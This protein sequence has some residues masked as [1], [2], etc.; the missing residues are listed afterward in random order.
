MFEEH[1]PDT[2]EVVETKEAHEVTTDGI[3]RPP[4]WRHD[5]RDS[6]VS[7]AQPEFEA[8]F[9]AV[10]YKIEGLI[11]KDS[12]GYGYG[13]TSLG[14][15]L[16][17]VLK[18]M[19]DNGLTIRQY[20]GK[21]HGLSGSGKQVFLPVNTKVTHAA[22]GQHEIFVTEV[23]LEPFSFKD[24]ETKKTVYTDILTPQSLGAAQTYARRYGLLAYFGIA[25]VD[26]D[27]MASFLEAAQEEDWK[28]CIE[29]M[30]NGMKQNKTL[31]ELKEWA[32]KNK[33]QI[34][35]IE[36]PKT[37]KFFV[38]VWN[39]LKATLPEELEEDAQ[40]DIEQAIESKKG[41]Q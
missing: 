32:A 27:A 40:L 10:Q 8:A 25:S 21:L 4:Y 31:A 15:V 16:P 38:E 18:V 14:K 37:Y 34:Q 5:V 9:A 2:G 36:H 26:N 19:K 22:T 6:L 28:A 13:Y 20:N 3:E 12:K 7:N 1:D 29:P 39:D 41:K 17:T 30:L 23:P 24:K 35:E 33:Q 11:E